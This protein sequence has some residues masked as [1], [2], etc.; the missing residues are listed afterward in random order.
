MTRCGFRSR[1]PLIASLGRNQAHQPNEKKQGVVDGP[2]SVGIIREKT[3][4]S[5]LAE[6]I[7][8]KIR[9]KFAENVSGGEIYDKEAA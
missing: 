5:I 2:Y 8:K 4:E 3:R 7:L 1:L 6:S 9:G